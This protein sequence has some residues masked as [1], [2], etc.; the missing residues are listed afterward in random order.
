[1]SKPIAMPDR[2]MKA[3][4]IQI[5]PAAGGPS[6][7][8]FT[9]YTAAVKYLNERVNFERTRLGR[10]DRGEFKLERMRAILAEMGDPHRAVKFVHVTGS[11]G[12]GSV[13]EMTA[14]CLRACG[15]TT[16]LYTSP[17]LV[18]VRERIKIGQEM[19]GYAAFTAQMEKVAAAAA[20]VEVEH[21]EAT[22]FEVITA[23]ALGHFAA[24]AVD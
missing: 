5:A 21:G 3:A 9:G 16:G 19:I 17:H 14:S 11:K 20:R 23:V 24:E 8:G 1:M 10:A 22:F 4:E 13:C 2:K 18:D 12:K 15:Y 6:S 7:E